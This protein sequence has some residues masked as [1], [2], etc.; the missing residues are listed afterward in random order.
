MRVKESDVKP[1]NGG[2]FTVSSIEHEHGQLASR[3]SKDG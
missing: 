2:D 1:H 3:G